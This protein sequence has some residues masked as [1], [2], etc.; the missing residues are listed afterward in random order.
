MQAAILAAL[1]AFDYPGKIGMA[2]SA[3]GKTCLYIDNASLAEGTRVSL[4]S[5]GPPQA[6]SEAEVLRKADSACRALPGSGSSRHRYA[7][8]VTKGSIEPGQPMFAV[9]GFRGPFEKRG[10]LVSAD[11]EGD[12]TR[13]FFRSCASSEGL[14]LTVWSGA[15]LSGTLRWHDYYYAGYD[16]EANCT[17]REVRG[18]SRL[19]LR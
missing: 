11:L 17:P 5:V 10:G 14:H 3:Q 8:R 19:R 15:P 18:P 9:A 2:V 6:V 1:L 13:E 16:L 4:V 12:G 7:I